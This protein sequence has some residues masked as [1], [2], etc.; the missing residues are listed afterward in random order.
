[1]TET[2]ASLQGEMDTCLRLKVI[3]NML[4]LTKNRPQMALYKGLNVRE[5]LSHTGIIDAIL[6]FSSTDSHVW[7]V[8]L[9]PMEGKTILFTSRKRQ[10]I[11]LWN[12][13]DLVMKTK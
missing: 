1:M 8:L 6:L 2:N 7:C 5:D 10:R 12:K 4:G 11:S 3:A 9:Q 13:A